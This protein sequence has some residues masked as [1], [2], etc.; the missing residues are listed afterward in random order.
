MNS[1]V[2][3]ATGTGRTNGT[4]YNSTSSP[5]SPYTG[6]AGGKRVEWAL[7][8]LGAVVLGAVML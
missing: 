5:I 3:A 1:S 4:Y 6:G 8:G 2:P 7:S